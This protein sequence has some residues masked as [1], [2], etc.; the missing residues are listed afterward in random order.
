MYAD[1]HL[2]FAIPETP[3]PDDYV[4]GT[5]LVKTETPDYMQFAAHLAVEELTRKL[6][7]PAP[8]N[9]RAGQPPRRQNR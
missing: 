6:G 4:I 7:S 9:P 8:R 2:L 3:N 5:Y 1:K